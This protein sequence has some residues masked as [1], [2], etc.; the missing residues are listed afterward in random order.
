MLFC[1]QDSCLATGSTAQERN[2][3]RQEEIESLKEAGCDCSMR[4]GFVVLTASS[5]NAVSDRMLAFITLP[6]CRPPRH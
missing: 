6:G 4:K 1:C 2:T 5:A 3:R